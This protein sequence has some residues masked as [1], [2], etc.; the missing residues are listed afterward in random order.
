MFMISRIIV[1]GAKKLIDNDIFSGSGEKYCSVLVITIIFLCFDVKMQ[2][3]TY[4]ITTTMTFK[5][6][7]DQT[8]TTYLGQH[9]FEP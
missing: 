2:F 1:N 7:T 3:L 9:N 8:M 5:L 4:E 6:K